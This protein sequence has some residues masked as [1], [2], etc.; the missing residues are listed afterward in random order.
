MSFILNFLNYVAAPKPQPLTLGLIYLPESDTWLLKSIYDE[1]LT[2]LRE[3]WLLSQ[4]G[5]YIVDTR[6]VEVS[7]K[8]LWEIWEILQA[9]KG[10]KKEVPAMGLYGE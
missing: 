5:G 2:K 9:I 7:G 1:I 8:A 6:G 3:D 10:T 4:V